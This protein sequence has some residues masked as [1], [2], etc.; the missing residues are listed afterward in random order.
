[1]GK[2]GN[3]YLNG[4]SSSTTTT[5]PN[6]DLK[7]DFQDA[8]AAGFTTV[9]GESIAVY[10]NPR[11]G[12]KED[13][14]FTI[15]NKLCV[16]F[17]YDLNGTKGPNQIGKDMGVISAFYKKD[18]VVVEPNYVKASTANAL[19][20]G[21]DTTSKTISK[22]CY[23][24][25]DGRVPN[26]E[27]L[28]SLYMNNKLYSLGS[29]DGYASTTRLTEGGFPVISGDKIIVLVGGEYNKPVICVEK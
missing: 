19:I 20:R 22:V 4:V 8:D 13:P 27:E 18:P 2:H 9:N 6:T 5:D 24:E 21:T 23:N 12:N 26:M 11:C 3:N 17:I 10:Y 28:M 16:N 14:P 25:A 7:D 1:M 29:L 15:K